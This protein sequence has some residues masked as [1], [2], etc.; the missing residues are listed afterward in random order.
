MSALGLIAGAAPCAPAWFA[1][2]NDHASSQAA[3]APIPQIDVL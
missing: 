2:T 3:N 1:A